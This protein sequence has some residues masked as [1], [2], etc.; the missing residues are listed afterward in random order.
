[1]VGMVLSFYLEANHSY[2]NK[3][4]KFCIDSKTASIIQYCDEVFTFYASSQMLF[5]IG[6]GYR[7]R[8]D[9]SDKQWRIK[10]QY[11]GY[12]YLAHEIL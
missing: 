12:D 3:G 5:Y 8:K 10:I 7:I 4:A 1:M 9:F 11:N 6:S 2:L